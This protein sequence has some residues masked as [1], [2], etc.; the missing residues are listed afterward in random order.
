MKEADEPDPDSEVTLDDKANILAML[1]TFKD[2]ADA[3]M[4]KCDKIVISVCGGVA[5]PMYVPENVTVEIR[6]YDTDGCDP[7]DLDD[8]GAAVSTYGD[9]SD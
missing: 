3:L 2:W 7:D 8:D 6:D 4:K 1:V 9:S 5:E